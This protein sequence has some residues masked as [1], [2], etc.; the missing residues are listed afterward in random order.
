MTT[1]SSATCTFLF[2]DI[3]GSTRLIQ[4]FP[5]EYPQ[6]LATVRELI[7]RP[8]EEGGGR[9][10]GTEGD[11]L[12]AA[13][14]SVTPAVGAAAAAQRALLGHDWPDGA[15]VSVRMGIHTGE[16]LT[17]GDNYVG[18]S[19]HQ[20]ARVMGA[21][22]GGQVLISSSTRHLAGDALPDELALRDLGEHRLKDLSMPERLFQLT[23]AGLPDE[24]PPLRTLSARPN[25]LP[26]QLTS[27]IGRQELA[28]AA[29]ALART[30][31]L[32]LSGPGGTG[33]TRLAL[34]L[35][36]EASDD[37]PDGVYFVPLEAVREAALVPASIA[38]ALG[39]SSA[40]GGPPD[41]RLLEHLRGKQTLLVLDNFEQVVDAGPF[42][43][44]M[45]REAPQTSRSLSPAAS[46]CAY[47]GSRTS[48]CRR[49]PARPDR[50]GHRRGRRVVPRPSSSSSSG[51]GPSCP[52]SR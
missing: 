25:N 9:V 42:V 32:T 22:H 34:Q 41:Q 17:I 28:A 8:I 33:K 11:A 37:F 44:T 50:P 15:K 47:T 21:G 38:A 10:F 26:T 13:F 40:S 18:L 12:F 35:A 23:G 3:E 36:A 46:S 19:L 4:A 43:T 29:E 31:L 20:V 1:G 52:A 6:L 24:F 2:A 49:W 30:R 48:R 45:L 7:T 14:E 16:A 5:D 27:F 39:L 51:R